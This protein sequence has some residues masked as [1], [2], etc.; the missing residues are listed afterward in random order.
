MSVEGRENPDASV[1]SVALPVLDST[2]LYEL[3]SS[4]NPIIATTGGAVYSPGTVSKFH[5]GLTCN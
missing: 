2:G 4:G 1:Y 5:H 3:D